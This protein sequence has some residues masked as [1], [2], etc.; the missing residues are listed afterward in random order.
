MK[1]ETFGNNVKKLRQAH[2]LTQ[3]YVASVLGISRRAYVDIENGK[4]LPRTYERYE[5]LAT[6]LHVDISD[7]WLENMNFVLKTTVTVKR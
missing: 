5:A 3:S 6:V 7:L 1:K 2:G 4:A